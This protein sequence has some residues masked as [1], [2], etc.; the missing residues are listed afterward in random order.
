VSYSEDLRKLAVL[1]Y[2]HSQETRVAISKR[3]HIGIATLGRWIRQYREVGTFRRRPR[4]GGRGA[5]ITPERH[6]LLMSI[7]L[8]NPDYTLAEFAA[9]AERAFGVPVSVGMV[10]RA[11]RSAAI[12]R[13]KNTN[14]H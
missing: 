2:E 8:H 11:L 5:T 3:F 9:E 7:V 14:R 6:D 4:S 13:K 12:T 1:Q 10:F